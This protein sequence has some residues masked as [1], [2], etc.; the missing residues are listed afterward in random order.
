MGV[1][2][3][4]GGRGVETFG[5]LFCVSQNHVAVILSLNKTQTTFG[6]HSNSTVPDTDIIFLSELLCVLVL[7]YSSY[8]KVHTAKLPLLL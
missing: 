1:E 8:E 5:L 3:G 4:V 6:R 7:R 2:V